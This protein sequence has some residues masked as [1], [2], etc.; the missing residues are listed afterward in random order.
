MGNVSR[1]GQSDQSIAKIL[2][3]EENEND[4]N[5]NQ[6]RRCDRTKQGGDEAAQRLQWTAAWLVDFN[7]DKRLIL[8]GAQLCLQRLGGL[9][10]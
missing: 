10:L 2:A 9:L 4:E 7:R 5:N 6:E 8:S 3:L 1:S